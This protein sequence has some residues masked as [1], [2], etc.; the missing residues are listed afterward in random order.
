[1][2][3]PTRILRPLI[4]VRVVEQFGG[5]FLKLYFNSVNDSLVPSNS[6]NFPV[7]IL[8]IF[9]GILNMNCHAYM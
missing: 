1:M 2:K 8:V 6:K 5:V 4:P 3:Q 9:T 7:L